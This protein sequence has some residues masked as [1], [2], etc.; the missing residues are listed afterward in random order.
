M[1]GPGSCPGLLV[2]SV[3]L[4]VPLF[5]GPFEFI[6]I[7]VFPQP[8]LGLTDSRDKRVVLRIIW[9]CSTDRLLDSVVLDTN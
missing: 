3:E 7:L 9:R 4:Y 8:S 2:L 1:D 5:G 6:F